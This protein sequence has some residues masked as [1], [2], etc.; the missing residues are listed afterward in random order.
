MRN[1]LKKIKIALEAAMANEIDQDPSIPQ[2][3]LNDLAKVH[4]GIKQLERR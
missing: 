1:D 3:L 4:A 2:E